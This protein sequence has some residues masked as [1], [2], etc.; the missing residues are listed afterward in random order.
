MRFSYFKIADKNSQLFLTTKHNKKLTSLPIKDILIDHTPSLVGIL[1]ESGLIIKFIKAR[2]WHEYL[3][4]CWCHSRISKEIKGSELLRCLGLNVP[5]IYEIGFG[6][7]PST[8]HDYLG[9]YIMENLTHS[10]FYELS[11]LIKEKSISDLIR[12]KIM[13]SIY[14]GL[15]VMREN[16]IVFSDFHL[17]NIFA[18]KV[19]DITWIDTGVTTYSLRNNKKFRSKY[20]QSIT[21]YINYEY[22]GVILLSQGEKTI[23]EKLLIT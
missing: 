17:D 13:I 7:I 22:E 21:R 16:N 23:F 15:K 18:N 3:K 9:Y 1:N 2:S 6:I 4:L 11:K 20:N 14:Q 12:Q 10:D 5:T 19:G 8:R